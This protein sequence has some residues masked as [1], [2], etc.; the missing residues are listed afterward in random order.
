MKKHKYTI[1][2]T[3]AGRDAELAWGPINS[4]LNELEHQV[5]RAMRDLGL[6]ADVQITL[7]VDTGKEE[8]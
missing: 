1:E 5:Y 4:T 3:V 7:P 6:Q 2:V 8:T